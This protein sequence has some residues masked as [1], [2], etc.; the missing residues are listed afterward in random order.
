MVRH[1]KGTSTYWLLPGGG[2][3]VGETLE[4]ALLRELREEANV[5]IQLEGLVFVN[6][7]IASDGSRHMVQCAF[8]AD[9]IAGEISAG[10]D[11]RVVEVR[12]VTLEELVDLDI[13]P[14]LKSELLRGIEKGFAV[15]SSY[16]G[17]RWVE[18]HSDD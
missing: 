4:Q 17:N 8:K 3:D 11:E 1:Q 13:H 16:L 15:T 2:V 14:P 18:D 10:V 9:I 5:D 12:F 6:D 7:A